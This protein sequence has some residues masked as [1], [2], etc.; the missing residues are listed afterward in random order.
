MLGSQSD[1][2]AVKYRLQLQCSFHYALLL[3][4]KSRNNN[5]LHATG[6]SKLTIGKVVGLQLSADMMACCNRKTILPQFP[7]MMSSKCLDYLAP[8]PLSAF[9][10]EL[11]YIIHATS[12]LRPL[13][14]D[15]W[16][17]SY[18]KLI[19]STKIEE[20]RR[21]RHSCMQT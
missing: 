4:A 19:K 5:D 9:G 13:F 16:M 12:L 10:T 1:P 15:I 7:D 14:H 18:S 2:A 3:R 11:C 21:R 6:L 8:P 20:K 17:S